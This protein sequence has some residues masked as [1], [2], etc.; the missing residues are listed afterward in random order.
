MNRT[1]PAIDAPPQSGGKV[2]SFGAE[3]MNLFEERTVARARGDFE[4]AD[5][6]RA[7]LARRGFSV[8]DDPGGSRIWI[9]PAAR[10]TRR[11]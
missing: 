5:R 4:R 6:L 8:E 7:E 10:A 2:P 3:V 9:G 11:A 1:P